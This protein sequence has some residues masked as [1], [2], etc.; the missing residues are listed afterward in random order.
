[1]APQNTQATGLK[2]LSLNVNDLKIAIDNL[3]K[4]V[5]KIDGKLESKSKDTDEKIINLT[6]KVTETEQSINNI[7]NG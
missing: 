4:T 6:K 3:T 2:S 7:L 5:T 1:M